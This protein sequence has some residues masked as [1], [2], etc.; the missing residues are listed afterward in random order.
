MTAA[1]APLDAAAEGFAV[2]LIED[3]ARGVDLRPGDVAAAVEQMRSAGVRVVT[4]AAA[5]F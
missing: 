4:A 2:T 3:A 5:R 1:P